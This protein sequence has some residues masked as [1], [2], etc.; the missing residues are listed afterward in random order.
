MSNTYPFVTELN[1]AT[2]VYQI[3]VEGAQG[4]MLVLGPDSSLNGPERN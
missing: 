4:L 1:P 2:P 3:L